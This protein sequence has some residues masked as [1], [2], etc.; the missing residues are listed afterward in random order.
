MYVAIGKPKLSSMGN[1]SFIFKGVKFAAYRRIVARGEL[2]HYADLGLTYIIFY[3]IQNPY[4]VN[5]I[6]R[7]HQQ[8]Y[9]QPALQNAIIIKDV[10]AF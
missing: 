9:Q 1:H 4:A 3:K 2:A 8:P 7:K 6:S 5:H 10:C